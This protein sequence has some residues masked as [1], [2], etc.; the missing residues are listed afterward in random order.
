MYRSPS[1]TATELDYF[2]IKSEKFVIDRSSRYP[3]FVMI[4]ND[5]NA[6]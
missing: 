4:T 3:H 2:I 1:Q 6:K 5:F